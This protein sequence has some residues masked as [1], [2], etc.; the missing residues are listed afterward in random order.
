M[1]TV[2]GREFPYEEG[3]TVANLLQKKGYTFKMITVKINGNVIKKDEYETTLIRDGDNV[4]VLHHV[5]GG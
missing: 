1:I 4:Q 2:N 5:A 3:L